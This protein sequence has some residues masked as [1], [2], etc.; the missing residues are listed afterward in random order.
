MVKR[1]LSESAKA[2]KMIKQLLK[3]KFPNTKFSVGS[4]NFAGGDAVDIGWTDGATTKAVKKITEQFQDGHFDGMQDMYVY[5][6]SKKHPTAKYVQTQR[7]MS[8]KV[9]AKLLKKHNKKYSDELKIKDLD[10][11]SWD[12][13]RLFYDAFHDT[14][15]KNSVA[16]KI[17]KK[18]S[19][20]KKKS[21]ALPSFDNDLKKQIKS[22]TSNMFDNT[23]LSEEM[24][25]GNRNLKTSDSR[26]IMRSQARMKYTE[27]NK[28]IAVDSEQGS[29]Q[30]LIQKA[31]DKIAKKGH[32][33]GIKAYGQKGYS[34]GHIDN[35]NADYEKT[36][37]DLLKQVMEKAEKNRKK[38]MGLLKKSKNNI[39]K[40]Y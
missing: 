15:F 2:S 35:L 17:Q 5:G 37:K 38:R 19:A 10:T 24:Y 33:W 21:V 13:R 28:Y 7:D 34:V 30:F 16:K 22:L 14:S 25:K 3:G 32:V 23:M 1:Q 31:D 26:K 29:G 18:R 40:N 9:K 27:R 4:R 11:A 6:K 8:D 36:N 20:P 12:Q 39:L